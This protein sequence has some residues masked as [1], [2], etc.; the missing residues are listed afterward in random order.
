M[1]YSSHGALAQLGARHT[2]SVEVRGSNPLCSI[3]GKADD[4][5]LS[6]LFLLSQF[7]LCVCVRLV[8]RVLDLHEKETWFGEDAFAMMAIFRLY[9]PGT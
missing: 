5:K 4:R 7:A 2:G 3:S 8:V 1:V 9:D 6:R